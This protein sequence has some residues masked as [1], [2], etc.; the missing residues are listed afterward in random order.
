MYIG[1]KTPGVSRHTTR[2]KESSISL[3]ESKLLQNEEHLFK[4]ESFM[5]MNDY[6]QSWG[7]DG[8]PAE[9]FQILKDDAVKL[10]HSICQQVWKPQQWPQD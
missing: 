8:I 10:L 3:Q 7:S 4:S 2:N 9:L 6:E 5:T 1:K